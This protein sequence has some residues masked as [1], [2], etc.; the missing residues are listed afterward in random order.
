MRRNSI[1]TKFKM[2]SS[3]KESSSFFL[4]SKLLRE[5]IDIILSEI[6]KEKNIITIQ[7][8]ILDPLLEYIIS[9]LK[10]FIFISIGIVMI[11]FV[12]IIALI[13]KILTTDF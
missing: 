4:R 8:D 10:P 5:I 2:D 9:K 7:N 11:L 1:E 13:Y 3:S 12:L 6:Q